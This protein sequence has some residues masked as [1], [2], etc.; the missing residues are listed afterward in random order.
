MPKQPAYNPVED[1][2][3]RLPKGWSIKVEI[4][5]TFAVVNLW[6]WDARHS[7]MIEMF[8]LDA[9]VQDLDNCVLFLIDFAVDTQVQMNRQVQ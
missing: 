1:A 9:V 7:E 6:R 5:K 8:T 4:T 3:E 2:M